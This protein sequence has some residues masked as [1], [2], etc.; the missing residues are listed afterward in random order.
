MLE[1]DVKLTVKD[2]YRFNM[3]QTY[4]GMQGWLSVVVA[5]VLWART[6]Q[7]FGAVELPYTVFCTVLGLVFLLY[8]PVGLYARSK[9]SLEA[10]GVLKETLH[11]AVDEQG[12]HVS[13]G[14]ASAVLAWEQIYKMVAAKNS[15]LVYSTR[16][17]AYI[18]PRE[19]LG[20][21]YGQLAKL[22]NAKLEK[23]RVKMR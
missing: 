21:K 1:F 14:E 7:S 18:I 10:S 11:F 15:V 23:H 9:H 8:F 5:I 16:I 2:M 12:F 19:Q 13:Q 20:D 4:S 22:A 17:N 3:Y 6:I